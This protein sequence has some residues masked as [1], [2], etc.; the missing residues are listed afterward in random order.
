MVGSHCRGLTRTESGYGEGGASRA[1]PAV[2]LHDMEDLNMP[3]QEARVFENTIFS[4][5]TDATDS[6]LPRGSRITKIN[7]CLECCKERPRLVIPF[8]MII[9]DVKY[10]SKHLLY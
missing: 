8:E 1:S 10:Y 6:C 7:G 3:G 9:E 5:N 2:V 4:Q